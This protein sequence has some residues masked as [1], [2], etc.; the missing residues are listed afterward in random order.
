L[1]KWLSIGVM[2]PVSIVLGYS[3]FMIVMHPKKF[4]NQPWESIPNTKKR[5]LMSL[6]LFSGII[7]LL[8]IS[9]LMALGTIMISGE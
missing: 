6:M 5:A 4:F 2:I 1:L 9:V 8:A 3:G 7:F